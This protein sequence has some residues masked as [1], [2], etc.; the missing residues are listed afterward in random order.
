MDFHGSGPE[1]LEIYP[2]L[3]VR[4][5]NIKTNLLNNIKILKTS[6]NHKNS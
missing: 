1:L 6:K 2:A 3:D 5:G 4:V